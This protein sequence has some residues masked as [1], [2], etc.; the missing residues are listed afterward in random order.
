MYICICMAGGVNPFLEYSD[1]FR[2]LMTIYGHLRCSGG[3]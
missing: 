2:C 1:W 3:G